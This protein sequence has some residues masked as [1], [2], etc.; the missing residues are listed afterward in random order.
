MKALVLS[1][2]IE[3]ADLDDLAATVTDKAIVGACYVSHGDQRIVED[4]TWRH[5]LDSIIRPWLRSLGAMG[6]LNKTAGVV[7]ALGIVALAV[8]AFVKGVE[9]D[10]AV[11]GTVITAVAG[12]GIVV[13]Q[14][15]RE[16]LQEL[17]RS[18]RLQMGPLY[19]QLVEMMK[20]WESSPINR[21]ASKRP[22]SRTY[23]PSSSCLEPHPS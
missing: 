20:D 13:Y 4:Y 3:V 12:I 19:T 11:V 10:P 16:K 23:R 5:S 9:K 1:A 2:F 7:A 8:W 22:S 14:R 17:E 15:R 21:R 6:F 18:H